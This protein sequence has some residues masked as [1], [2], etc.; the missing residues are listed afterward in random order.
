MTK[1]HQS[2]PSAQR[3]NFLRNSVYTG[4]GV[5]AAVLA[6]GEAGAATVKTPPTPEAEGSRGYQE[7]QHIRDYYRTASF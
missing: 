5:A 2:L 4:A 1:Q 3:R 7:T 6:G